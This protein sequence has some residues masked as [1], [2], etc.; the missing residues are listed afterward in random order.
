MRAWAT[1]SLH[2]DRDLELASEPLRFLIC[3]MHIRVAV[4]SSRVWR[5]RACDWTHRVR[6]P[7][8]QVAPLLQGASSP[9][10]EPEATVQVTCEGGRAGDR[11]GVE[12]SEGR[13]SGRL[14]S[15]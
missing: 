3:H 2:P 15:A 14:A 4:P 6:C 11:A 10:A 7:L 5:L 1:R 13:P 8:L 9:E 12:L